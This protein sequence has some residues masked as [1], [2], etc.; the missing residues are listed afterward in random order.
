M[1]TFK[2]PLKERVKV[3]L[4]KMEDSWAC[5]IVDLDVCL[6]S[7]F[8]SFKL[9]LFI[10]SF[11]WWQSSSRRTVLT[12]F[13]ILFCFLI[14]VDRSYNFLK[15]IHVCETFL[16][17]F[18]RSSIAPPVVFRSAEMMWTEAWSLSPLEF[19]QLSVCFFFFFFK[20]TGMWC[21]SVAER[22]RKSCKRNILPNLDLGRA[23]NHIP[24]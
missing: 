16:L 11:L 22:G 17:T 23:T 24:L 20:K 19:L 5:F 10:A 2:A 4:E 7:I 6:Y 12:S 8:M 14:S 1:A 18:F 21:L 15:T 9:F 3:A 13:F